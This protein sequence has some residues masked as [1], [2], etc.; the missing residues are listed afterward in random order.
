MTQVYDVAVN[1]PIAQHLSY[2]CNEA[3]PVGTLVKVPLGKRVVAGVVCGVAQPNPDLPLTKLKAVAQV[4]ECL[5]PLSAAWLDLVR[6]A[7][8]YYQRSMGE[9]ATSTL[10]LLLREGTPES[11]E[12]MLDKL[13]ETYFAVSE[14]SEAALKK[15][16]PL[17]HAALHALAQALLSAPATQGQASSALKAL[18]PSANSVI[19]RWL[20]RGWLRLLEPPR[21]HSKLS[22]DAAQRILSAQQ[23][24]ALTATHAP[25]ASD[26]PILLFGTTG[27]GKSEVY[28]RAAAAALERDNNAQILIL[29]PEINLTP[30][31]LT[32][33]EQ[34]FEDTEIVA[35][36]SGLSEGERLKSWLKAHL[37]I[38]QILIG[39]RMAV[40]ASL[41][42]LALIVVDEEHDASFKSQE[43]ARYSARD[44]A[45]YRAAQAKI[46]IVLGSATPSLESWIAA[47]RGRYTQVDMPERI[48]AAPLPKLRLV[49][50][51]QLPRE[52][53]YSGGLSNVVCEA[54]EARIAKREQTLIF[55]NRRGY[56]PVISC[57]QCG[58]LS[59]CAH[60]SAYQVFHKSD[61][62]LRCHHCSTT[63]RVPSACPSCGSHDLRPVGHGTQKLEEWL[64]DR[65]A[66]AR[67]TR[68]DA[69]TSR[70][71]GAAAAAFAEVHAGD[72]DILIG[73]Q[74]ITKGH[75]F[76]NVSLIVA[77]GA[78][79]ALYSA[80][81]RASERL[82]A[83]LMQ[84]AG[85]A[86]RS[87]LQSEIWV[88][89][90]FVIHPLFSALKAHD[91]AAFAS[92]TLQEREIAGVPP[93]SFLALMRAEGK[94]QMQAQDFLK[95]ARLQA[96]SLAQDA[97]ITLYSP[98]PMSM[99][100]IADVERAQ[101]LIESGSRKSLQAFLQQW[102]TALRSHKT[103]VRWAVDVD[104]LEI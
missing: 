92:R 3:L 59:D 70:R 100:R 39:T 34:A 23:S 12:R 36:H 29:V 27:S 90:D 22:H 96:E 53:R 51:R 69:D 89:T 83:Q 82:F 14:G 86:G 55:L 28:L 94:T 74:M 18:H 21:R 42:R 93:F 85:R 65:F 87:G 80:D 103:S 8:S 102:L 44:L 62:T 15:T 97:G 60:C 66:G 1:S 5:P 101:M 58:W 40:F 43:G 49:D 31:L 45:I 67:I 41:P 76:R 52:Q 33:F 79:S 64:I 13:S 63:R 61:R 46:P 56:A 48:S 10:P 99:Q 17:R 9:L 75:D 104:P 26:K 95:E 77:L 88:Q 68:I 78:D 6:F 47:E 25:S 37:G 57:A 2:L 19:N 32:Q 4:F 71:K 81:F 35:L 38:A 50:A 30:Q 91:Y 16:A 24:L 73:T 98:V 20:A 54:I 72:T 11:V 7:A 84:A